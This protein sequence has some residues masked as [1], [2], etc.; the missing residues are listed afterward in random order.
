MT[1]TLEVGDQGSEPWPEQTTALY[2]DRQAGRMDLVAVRAV[3]LVTAMFL[4]MQGN[5][6]HVDL[7]DDIRSKAGGSQAMPTI[8]TEL[9]LMIEGA[10]QFG[11]EQGTLML[12][13]TGLPTA[14]AGCFLV[15]GRGLGRLDDVRRR[16][17]GRSRGVLVGSSKPFLKLSDSRF[18]LVDLSTLGLELSLQAPATRTGKTT[19]LRHTP[20]VHG[21]SCNGWK[22]RERLRT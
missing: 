6:A 22:W 8:G 15:G 21:S 12:G 16:G 11:R 13:M 5:V 17:L 20:V 10:N 14:G 1:Y 4:D 19:P 18:Q 7:L 9:Q 3:V 2:G